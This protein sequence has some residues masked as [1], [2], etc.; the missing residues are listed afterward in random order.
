MTPNT[1]L[2]RQ[3]SAKLKIADSLLQSF[4]LPR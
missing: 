1:S 4:N 3:Q 2:K